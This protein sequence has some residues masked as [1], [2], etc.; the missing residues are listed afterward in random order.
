MHH[1]NVWKYIDELKA[2]E[3]D[4]DQILAQV[5][6]EIIENSQSTNKNIR[7]ANI[8]KSYEEYKERGGAVHILRGDRLQHKCTA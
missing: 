4:F 1:A 6:A 5:K 2:K 8:A 7:C 3:H